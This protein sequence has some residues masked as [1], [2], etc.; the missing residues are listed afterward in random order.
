V[1]S[2]KAIKSGRSLDQMKADK[3]LAQWDEWGP[4]G[5][6][7]NSDLTRERRPEPR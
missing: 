4:Q 5:W 1:R 6:F 7:L 3:I 2:K